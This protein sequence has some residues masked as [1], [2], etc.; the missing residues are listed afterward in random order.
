MPSSDLSPYISGWVDM[1]SHP[2]A[3][4]PSF[5]VVLRDFS[6]FRSTERDGNCFYSSFLSQL[7]IYLES[8]NKNEYVAFCRILD[9]S[10]RL[11]ECI[12]DGCAVYKDFYDVFLDHVKLSRESHVSIDKVSKMDI[13]GM[14]TYLKILVKVELMSKKEYYH[15][16]L[17]ETCIDD[18][19]QK[20]VDPL[21]RD[22]EHLEI[23]AIANIL[24]INIK[25]FS[26]TE[27]STEISEF[28]EPGPS[29]NILHT[30]NHFEPIK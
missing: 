14:I 6:H 18:Y 15:P 29:L 23:Q 2:L 3:S 25:V 13:L 10:N 8:I 27:Q 5:E 12:R 20:R 9:E 17:I 7:F 22:T 30:T 19:C 26:V 16:F 11:Y 21:F 1:K 4:F 24:R 28:G